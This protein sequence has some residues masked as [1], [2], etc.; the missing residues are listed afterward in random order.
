MLIVFRNIIKLMKNALNKMMALLLVGILI[1]TGLLPGCVPVRVTGSGNIV[2]RTFN[3][4]DF[5]KIRISYGFTAEVRASNRYSIEITADDNLFDYISVKKDGDMISIGL[6]AGSYEQSHLQATIMMPSL[7]G[8]ELSDGGRTDVSG[9]NS[10]NDLSVKL[11]DGTALSGSLTAGN[12][13]ITLTDGSRIELEG[14]AKDIKIISHDGSKA[15]L[16]NFTV[17][18]TDLNVGDGGTLV[19]NVTG[20]L[21]AE[22]SAGSHVTYIGNPTMGAIKL[23]SGATLSKKE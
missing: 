20:T 12:V 1:I 16:E 9:F 18:N 14:S 15:N 17:V 21:N 3:F 19:I 5:T 4:I 22:L 13:D 8:I 2:S 23:S 11:S 10:S 6:R 7:Y